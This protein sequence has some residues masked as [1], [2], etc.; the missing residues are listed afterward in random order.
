MSGEMAIGG[1]RFAWTTAGK[2]PPLLVVNGYAATAA[3]WD[4]AFLEAVGASFELIC[5]D[6]R[7]VGRSELGDPSE[8]NI[9]AMVQDLERLLG[10]L[11]LERTAVLGWSMGGFIAQGL[12]ERSPERVRALALLSTDPGGPGAVRSDPEVWARLIDD[13]VE[14]SP[15][16]QSAQDAAID[17]W[18]ATDLPPLDPDPPPVLAIAGDQ[19]VVI[20]PEN[21]RLLAERWP[22]CRVE[23]VEGG[24]H[25]VMAQEPERVAELV[26]GFFAASG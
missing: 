11:G 2:G 6:N 20:P 8:V 24:G 13:S 3:D 25:A 7:G 16:A 15:E 14:L 12:V 4:P 5:P 26:A 1:R 9:D 22:R 17:R 18:Y 21:A 19:D 10:E 23:L